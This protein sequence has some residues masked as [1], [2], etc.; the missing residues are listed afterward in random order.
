MFD[1]AWAETVV[2]C[3]VE[4]LAAEYEA[5]GQ[6][7]LFDAIKRYL[8]KPADRE[9]YTATGQRLGLSPDAV[10]MA[11]MRLRRRYRTMVRAEVANTVSTPAEVDDEMRY[12][13]ELLTE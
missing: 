11:V 2:Q 10:A 7:A 1:R 9:A 8:S 5:G 13:V 3:S 12:L 6:R 4:Q